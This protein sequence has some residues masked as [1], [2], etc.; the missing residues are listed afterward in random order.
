MIIAGVGRRVVV[1]HGADGD[2]VG[3]VAGHADGHRIGAGVAGSGDDDDAGLPGTH[4]GLVERIVPVIGLRRAAERKVEHADVVR[5][6]VGDNPVD[7]AN[8]IQIAAGA[9]GVKRFD[10]HQVGVG[11]DA[12]VGTGVP[13]SGA[14]AYNDAGHMGSVTTFIVDVDLLI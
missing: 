11:G 12:V 4:D 8:D 2:D 14:T 3:H 13:T 10:G 9:V 5:V 1:G 6:F 7:A